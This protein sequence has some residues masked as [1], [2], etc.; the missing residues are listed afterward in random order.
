MT[1]AMQF[2]GPVHRRR[3][4]GLTF[5]LTDPV[6]RIIDRRADG[7]AYGYETDVDAECETCQE[8]GKT[9][10]VLYRAWRKPAGQWGPWVVFRYN[11]EKHVPDMSVPIRVSTLPRDATRLSSEEAAAYWHSS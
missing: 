7:T 11:G 4:F 1:S 2:S 5:Y 3:G 6:C 10:P 9:H 8:C